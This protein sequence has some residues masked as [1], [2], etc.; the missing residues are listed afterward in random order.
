M[1]KEFGFHVEFSNVKKGKKSFYRN[2]TYLLS[3]FFGDK[4]S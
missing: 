4:L 2:F 3:L 1:F